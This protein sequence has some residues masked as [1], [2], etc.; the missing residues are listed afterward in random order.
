MMLLFSKPNVSRLAG[1]NS[2]EING[3]GEAICA[4]P[5]EPIRVCVKP[6]R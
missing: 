1:K 6:A 3:L 2:S 4:V 5:V